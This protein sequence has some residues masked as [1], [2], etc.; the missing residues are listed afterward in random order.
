MPRLVCALVAPEL[1]NARRKLQTIR[2]RQFRRLRDDRLDQQGEAVDGKSRLVMLVRR[3][4][5]LPSETEGHLRRAIGRDAAL[6]LTFDKVSLVV[7]ERMSPVVPATGPEPFSR[8]RPIV[9][10]AAAV[11][12][13]VAAAAV[14]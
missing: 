2:I 14:G 9:A 7:D 5:P 6:Y 10:R 13:G 8:A 1:E 11:G 4:W 3:V 12:A